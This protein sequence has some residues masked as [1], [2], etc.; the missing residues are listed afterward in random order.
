MIVELLNVTGPFAGLPAELLRGIAAHGVEL[1]LPA[2]RTLFSHGDTADAVFLVLDGT[3]TL[4]RDQ[5]GRPLQLLA[6]LG[7]GDLVGEHCLFDDERR[8]ATARVGV[9][10]RLL[11]LERAPLRTLLQAEPHLA[12]R[13]QNAAARRRNLNAAAALQLGQQ[14]EVRIRLHAAAR[15]TLA[16]GAVL[17][18]E[19]ENL[20]VGGV[21][22]S[23]A[24]RDWEP[25]H[26]VH[27]SLLADEEPLPANGRVAWREG[28]TVGVAFVDPHP[29][30]ERH[31]YRLLR[32][33][34]DG[35]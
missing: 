9:A 3:V 33:L 15:L 28:E 7:S 23:G 1:R 32:K 31:V 30:H 35:G 10:C 29:S 27:F 6:R 24:P 21:S 2:G 5:V 14:S 25:G 4:Y 22:L 13:V 20:S 19:I 26:L 16:N 18:V 8:S 34:G 11:R 17:P 12:L